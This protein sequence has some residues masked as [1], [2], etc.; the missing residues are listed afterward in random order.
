MNRFFKAAI[1]IGIAISITMSAAAQQAPGP[2]FG[3]EV[4]K[5]AAIY[6]SRGEAVPGGYVVDRSLLAYIAALRPGFKSALADL[7][8]ADR[9]LD[10]GAGRGQAVLDYYTPRYD[11][12]HREGQARRG[13]KAQAVAM[14]IED[15]RTPAWGQTATGLEPEQI[16]YLSGKRLR[17]YTR[18][19]LGKFQLITD[20]FGGFSYTQ[21][22]SLF[23]EQVL[24][25]LEVNG[26]FYTTLID[27][28]PESAESL[29]PRQSP[30]LTEIANADG[31]AAGVCAWLKSISCVE[32]ACELKAK[33][34]AP[35]EAYRVRKVCDKVVIPELVV[36]HF[37]AGTPP[38]RRFQARDREL[39]M[40]A[41]GRGGAA[42]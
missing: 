40:A 3:D 1:P 10:I 31:S 38:E 14:S 18:A 28:A 23:M 37:V 27:V 13:K 26:S 25:I 39:L 33:W 36:T 6:Q 41:P 35:I 8:P 12:M 29:Q 42:H 16:R 15:R 19:E 30:F 34:A 20:V 17:E 7:K 22:L 9:W 2:A 24:G 21:Y 5:Q 32:V 4:S 11:A